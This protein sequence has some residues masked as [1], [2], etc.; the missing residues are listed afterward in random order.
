MWTK[1]CMQEIQLFPPSPP[2]ARLFITFWSH[3]RWSINK[4][5]W[6]YYL[7]FSKWNSSTRR[8]LE[9][10]KISVSCF[11]FGLFSLLWH[12]HW[13]FF[14]FMVDLQRSEKTTTTT[15]M[16]LCNWI[17]RAHFM[18]YFWLNWLLRN[19]SKVLHFKCIF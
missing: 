2:T 10:K 3:S 7:F 16:L 18:K 5:Y 11:I 9:Q 1:V 6:N 19:A 12:F 15:S 4:F 8:L 17:N 14:E 13:T